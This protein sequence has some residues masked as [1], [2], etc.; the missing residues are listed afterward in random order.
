VQALRRDLPAHLRYVVADEDL[1][2]GVLRLGDGLAADHVPRVIVDA[3]EIDGRSYH[4]EVAG[5]YEIHRAVELGDHVAG[6]APPRDRVEV[7][8]VHRAVGAVSRLAVGEAARGGRVRPEVEH[9]TH[10][11][12][13]HGLPD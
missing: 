8:A 6:V 2:R 4:V 1:A 13:R 11:R 3:E 5:L 12:A 7:P 10:V 9:Q